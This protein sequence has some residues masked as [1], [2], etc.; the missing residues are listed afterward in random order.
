[1]HR[2]L[3]QELDFALGKFRDVAEELRATNEELGNA[4]K[5]HKQNESALV[6]SKVPVKL[7]SVCVTF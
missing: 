2:C 5:V 7:C 6:L 1:M 4:L 3:S